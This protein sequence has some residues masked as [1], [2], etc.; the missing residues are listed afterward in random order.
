[1]GERGWA[2]SNGQKTGM[3]NEQEKRRRGRRKEG[4]GRRAKR[5][6]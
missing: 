4:G 3:E 1:M 6:V 2:E 5:G